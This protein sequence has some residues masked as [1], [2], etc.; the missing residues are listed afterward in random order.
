[1]KSD[2]NVDSSAVNVIC[3]LFFYFQKQF[4]YYVKIGQDLNLRDHEITYYRK[5]LLIRYYTLKN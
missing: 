3:S 1:M 2:K 5:R 4:T